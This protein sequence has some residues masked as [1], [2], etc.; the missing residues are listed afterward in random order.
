MP[1]CASRQ[2]LRRGEL[3]AEIIEDPQPSLFFAV[4][5]KQGTAEILFLGQYHSRLAATEAATQYLSEFS[6]RLR[7]A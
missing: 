1:K 5:Q 2:R 7:A 6:D 4:V 3:F